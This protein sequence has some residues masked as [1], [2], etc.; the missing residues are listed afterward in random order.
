M[1]Y[2][3][4]I[5]GGGPA[6][7]SAG[8]YSARMNMKA[9]V[10]AL[11]PGGLLTSIH[12]IENWP[13][14]KSINGID[15]ANNLM[16]HATGS[17][18][19][20]KYEEVI[21]VEKIKSEDNKDAYRVKTT[22][23]NYDAYTVM[24]ATGGKHRL[25]NVPG[26]KE[27]SGKGVSYCALC[28]A[29]FYKGKTVVVVGGGDAAIK[30]TL[31]LAEHCIKI[32]VIV[33]SV[34]R[35]EPANIKLLEQAPNV[36]MVYKE[37]V[38]EVVGGDPKA[39]GKVEKIKFKSGKE[40]VADGVFVA[41][42]TEPMNAIAKDLGVILNEKGEIIVNRKSETNLPGIYSAGDCTDIEVK[43]AILGSAQAV[44]ASYSAFKYTRSL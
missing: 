2:G 34:L 1:T 16:E 42:G 31:V 23:G 22:S 37:E 36:E 43:Q 32:Y 4:I 3:I 25:L 10:L 15:L 28:D 40:I 5:I 39:G 20:I 27:F 13:G 7:L 35:A 29:N 12:A 6:G 38:A 21:S 17:G 9:L 44:M 19:E 26:E 30:D 33:R 18:A 24:F 14:E 41:I 11:M 8:M